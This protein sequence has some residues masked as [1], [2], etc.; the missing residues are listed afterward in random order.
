MV[1]QS[2]LVSIEAYVTLAECFFQLLAYCGRVS[3]WC[4]GLVRK[5]VADLSTIPIRSLVRNVANV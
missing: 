5:L 3:D 2:S 4:F 1:K